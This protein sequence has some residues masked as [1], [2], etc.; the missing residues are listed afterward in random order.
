MPSAKDCLLYSEGLSATELGNAPCLSPPR[1]LLLHSTLYFSH[2]IL[3]NTKENTLL[4]VIRTPCTYRPKEKRFAQEGMSPAHQQFSFPCALSQTHGV[5]QR[6]QEQPAGPG[7][8]VRSPVQALLSSPSPP[9]ARRK[10]RPH[11][12][13]CHIGRRLDGLQ[14]PKVTAVHR[15][16]GQPPPASTRRGPVMVPHHMRFLADPGVLVIFLASVT[17]L[18]FCLTVQ[19]TVSHN[20]ERKNRVPVSS[21]PVRNQR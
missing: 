19:G 21:H 12:L 20:G 14:V 3:R 13:S 17:K 4:T 5:T 1:S 15:D 8:E 9:A 11:R 16:S 18:V 7:L 2:F 10:P 6:W